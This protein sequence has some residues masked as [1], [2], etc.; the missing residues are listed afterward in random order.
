MRTILL[1]AIGGGVGAIFRYLFARSVQSL[2]GFTFPYG[3]LAVNI[4]GSFLIGLLSWILFSRISIQ[5]QD[6]RAL[7]I[8]GLL[9]GFTTFSS[10]SLEAIDLLENREFFKTAFY[11]IFSVILCCFATWCGLIL[12]RKI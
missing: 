9:G 1:I 12:G 2:F 6:L 8:V 7:L 11:L 10:F 5:S 3:T 4:T